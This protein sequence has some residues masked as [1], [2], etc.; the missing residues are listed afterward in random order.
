MILS[1][2]KYL[3]ENFR[4]YELMKTQIFMT[5]PYG[6]RAGDPNSSTS[7]CWLFLRV[8]PTLPA[9]RGY[10]PSI[11]FGILCCFL[12]GDNVHV[13][14]GFRGRFPRQYIWRP[15]FP[16]NASLF[17]RA[18]FRHSSE[19]QRIFFGS[20]CFYFYFCKAKRDTLEFAQ[21]YSWF[22]LSGEDKRIE[23]R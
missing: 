8:S 16:R 13:D 11:F 20:A 17:Q 18:L 10:F 2:P 22:Y 21:I 15:W 1:Y 23:N 3:A 12:F 14:G 5:N 6:K 4:T 19:C 7:F 9:F